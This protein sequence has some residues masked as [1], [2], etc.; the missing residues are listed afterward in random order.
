MITALDIAQHWPY[1]AEHLLLERE[2]AADRVLWTLAEL[3]AANEGGPVAVSRSRLQGLGLTAGEAGRAWR[4]LVDLEDAKVV[5]RYRGGG[6][7]RADLWTFTLD[8]RHW[9]MPWRRSGYSVA[10]AIEFCSCSSRARFALAARSPGL[11]L[12]QPREEP[13]FRLPPG[14]HLDFYVDFRAAGRK[15]RA[16]NDSA[17]WENTDEP[18][19][20]AHDDEVPY[21]L[22]LEAKASLLGPESKKALIDKAELV[23]RHTR[24]CQSVAVA[25]GV[26]AVFGGSEFSKRLRRVVEDLQDV[27]PLITELRSLGRLAGLE[28]SVAWVEGRA[29]G[30]APERPQAP[31]DEL[32][33]RRRIAYLERLVG[34]VAEDDPSRKDLLAE[35][36]ACQNELD[37]LEA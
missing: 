9:R 7:R 36:A 2:P 1:V 37:R 18:R 11:R 21:T 14:A 31:V 26:Q 27:E 33:V 29:A 10:H 6:G 3:Q 8:V 23:D 12:V 5:T 19:G 25:S 24:L 28:E 15:P 17:T 22:P 20:M 30:Y 32:A 35:L 34:E 4:R 13:E 16:A